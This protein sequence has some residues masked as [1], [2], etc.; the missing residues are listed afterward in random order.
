MEGCGEAYHLAAQVQH[1]AVGAEYDKSNVVGTRNI[2]TAARELGIRRLVYS[3]SIII[4]ANDPSPMK[5]ESA[6]VSGD[7][8]NSDYHR[9][10]YYAHLEATR[11]AAEGLPV[12][13]VMPASVFGP[14]DVSD[15][16]RVLAWCRRFRQGRVPHWLPDEG[17]LVVNLAYGEDVARGILLAM[18]RGNPGEGYILGGENISIRDLMERIGR[19]A[20]DTKP[21][22]NI[23]PATLKFLA[24]LSEAWAGFTRTRPL[25]GRG[26]V[27][28]LR[29]PWAFSSE[30]AKRELGYSVT[31][32]EDALRATFDSA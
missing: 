1:V 14:R 7:L 12:I 2:L 9:T 16:N 20:G 29:T 6:R 22:R 27:R 18:R 32:F 4:Y 5:D 13:L 25:L 10:K 26:L 8:F 17:R 21:F 15:A 11:F 3:S 31:P 24:A 28:S 23:P 30:K 19:L